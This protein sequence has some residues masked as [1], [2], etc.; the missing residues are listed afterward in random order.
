MKTVL[1]TGGAGFIG[2]HIVDKLLQKKYKVIVADN[3]STGN[4]KFLPK[5]IPFIKA[6]VSKQKEV[7][8][9][10][11]EN[12]IH[13][14]IH[15]AGQPSI[16]NSFTDPSLDFSTNFTG[17]MNMILTAKKYKVKRFLYASSMTVYGNQKK[18]P[19][20][21]SN[22]CVPINYYGVAKYAAERFVHIT[23]EKE[24]MDVT[25]FRMFNVYGPRQSL[26]NPYQGV[27]AIFAGNVLRNEQ[28]TIFGDG[29][30]GRD[31]VY[32]D[33]VANVWVDAIENEKSFGEIFNIGNGRQ[34]SM[35]TL[36]KTVIK[37]CGE[38]PKKYPIIFKEKRPGDQRYIEA[39]IT[40]AR[41]LLHFNPE[42]PLEEGLRKT[43]T[44]A[45]QQ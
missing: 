19:I 31:F 7:E 4:K 41:K 6:D 35:V 39:D 13:I 27:L 2:S 22:P 9:V 32:V 40:K 29:K 43:L 12:K 36:A 42:F 17:T 14:V 34:T 11:A 44:W 28:I 20:E 30:Q 18:L 3:L 1:V 21:E 33:D 15:I 5:D 45:K 26:T 23:A 24:N 37:A 8:K 16:V 38:D 10:F 25:S